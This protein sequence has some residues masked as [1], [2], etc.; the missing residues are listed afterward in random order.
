MAVYLTIVVIVSAIVSI[1]VALISLDWFFRDGEEST[2]SLEEF[3]EP[4]SLVPWWATKFGIWLAVARGSGCL[5]FYALLMAGQWL[6][7]FL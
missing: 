7:S 2:R 6:R 3:N 1:A 5:C 4:F